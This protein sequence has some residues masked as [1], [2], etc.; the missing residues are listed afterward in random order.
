M[1]NVATKLEDLIADTGSDSGFMLDE[2]ACELLR[3]E[4]VLYYHRYLA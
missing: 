4:A 3:S 1:P 2:R